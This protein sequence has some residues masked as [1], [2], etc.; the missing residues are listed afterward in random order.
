MVEL[1]FQ[2]CC[3]CFLLF[4][5]LVL[6]IQLPCCSRFQLKASLSHLS[7]EPSRAKA[8]NHGRQTIVVVVS[9]QYQCNAVYCEVRVVAIIHV[10]CTGQPSVNLV[11]LTVRSIQA[12]FHTFTSSCRHIKYAIPYLLQAIITRSNIAA[13]LLLFIITLTFL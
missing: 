2:Q 3:T 13:V 6:F 4:S 1:P 7:Q 5:R 10:S 8:G 9:L 11:H 12:D